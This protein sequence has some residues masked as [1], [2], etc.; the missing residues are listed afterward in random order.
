M[1]LLFLFF[2]GV[3]LGVDDDQ[4]NPLAVAD[5]PALRSLLGGRRLLMGSVPVET[6]RATLLPLDACLGVARLPQ[7]A[8]G[9]TALLTGI[10]VPARIG[11]HYGPK[12]TPEI[13]AILEKDNLFLKLARRGLRVAL[14]NAYPERYFE[15]IRSGKRIYSA[16]PMAVTASGL[17]LKNTQ[18]L[19]A[20]RALSADLTGQAWRDMLDVPEAPVLSPEEA[21]RQIVELSMGLDLAF[22]EYWITDYV[23]HR[24]DWKTAIEVLERIDRAL[25][26]ILDRWEDE[27]GLILFTSDHGNLENLDTRRHTRNSVPGLVIGA[28]HLRRRLVENLRDL[29]DV[30]PAIE[31][32][33]L[34]ER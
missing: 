24:Q 31:S 26:G 33:L 11:R 34:D 22:F 17:A 15:S 13:A 32:V 16:V 9:Q 8:T 6:E 23:G 21:G 4:R 19:L 10:N 14:L 2:D 20:G 5:M 18:D 1:R 29:T 30:A 27:E 25:R 3:G 7:S 12:P 28:P